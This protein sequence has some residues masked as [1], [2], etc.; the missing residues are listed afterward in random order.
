M[1]CIQ[2]LA[3]N[4]MWCTIAWQSPQFFFHTTKIQQI[5]CTKNSIW[6]W[7][8]GGWRVDGAFKVEKFI[9]LF[10]P[11]FSHAVKDTDLVFLIFYPC[12]CGW[13]WAG[14]DAAPYMD[15]ST[16]QKGVIY[17]LWACDQCIHVYSHLKL[18]LI[19]LN[20]IYFCQKM[21]PDFF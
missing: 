15:G 17:Q 10:P 20:H 7:F 21:K 2:N 18:N 12:W 1:T 13:T 9:W 4:V 11:A 3:E 19:N 5:N 16:S 6:P 14:T 8:G